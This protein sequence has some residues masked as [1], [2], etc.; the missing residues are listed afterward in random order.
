[1]RYDKRAILVAKGAT[2]YDPNVGRRVGTETVE[3]MVSC[4]LQP[5]SVEKQNAF[6]SIVGNVSHVVRTRH[7]VSNVNEI[8]IGKKRFAIKKFIDHGHHGCAYY[9]SEVITN[10]V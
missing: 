4:N 1:M 10:A 8:R 9:V 6:S 7:K 5:L 3:T 2:K